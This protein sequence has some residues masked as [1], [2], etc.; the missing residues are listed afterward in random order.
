MEGASCRGAV[1]GPKDPP[2]D[3]I[4]VFGERPDSYY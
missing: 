3:V 4:P 1:A 2:C